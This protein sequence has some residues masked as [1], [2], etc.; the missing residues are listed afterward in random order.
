MELIGSDGENLAIIHL[1][2]IERNANG[3][4][5]DLQPT[6]RHIERNIIVGVRRA[7]LFGRQ[8]HHV[9]AIVFRGHIRAAGH[10]F[11]TNDV[12]CAVA[13]LT[14]GTIGIETGFVQDF[15]VVVG[16]LPSISGSGQYGV[17]LDICRCDVQ[18]HHTAFA[19][20]TTRQNHH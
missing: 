9:L 16:R 8:S 12:I 2:G 19:A 15:G 18:R 17:D 10:C 7:E 13:I 1:A 20:D 4:L 6:V 11:R 14:F 3:L 5:G